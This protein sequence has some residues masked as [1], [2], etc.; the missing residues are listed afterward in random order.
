[1]KKQQLA[2]FATSGVLAVVIGVSVTQRMAGPVAG[3][4][5]GG[6]GQSSMM[7]GMP[8]GDGGMVAMSSSWS[9]PMGMSSSS[10]FGMM[11][12]SFS[13]E[14]TSSSFGTAI[15]AAI[16]SWSSAG[17]A[18]SEAASSF[19]SSFVSSITCGET[20]KQANVSVT[21]TTTNFTFG[22]GKKAQQLPYR[23]DRAAAEL[24]ATAEAEAVFRNACPAAPPCA[25]GCDYVNYRKEYKKP[26]P[27]TLKTRQLTAPPVMACAGG[28]AYQSTATVAN[29]SCNTVNVCAAPKPP[30][31]L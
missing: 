3:D 19:D 10:S 29:E 12:S 24:S 7:M 15:S 11:M 16:S 9:E 30:R 5:L 26:L 28:K 18:V 17:N 31:P 22:T 13:M 6:E 21:A 2:L 1:M 20:N 25:Q 27:V 23:C 4:L 8:S 14:S